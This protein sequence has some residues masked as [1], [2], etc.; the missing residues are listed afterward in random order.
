M[1]LTAHKTELWTTGITVLPNVLSSAEVLELQS[2]LEKPFIKQISHLRL[3]P[4]NDEKLQ[5]LFDADM[6][7]Y[8]AAAKLA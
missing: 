1:D 8:L 3:K 4:E 5:C 2:K 6:E 7:R